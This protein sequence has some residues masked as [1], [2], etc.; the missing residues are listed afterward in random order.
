MLQDLVAAALNSALDKIREEIN[1]EMGAMVGMPNGIPGMPGG[2]PGMP[3][4]IPGM[5]GMPGGIP[6]FPT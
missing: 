6:G 3:G 1:R 4:G 2:I 5:P